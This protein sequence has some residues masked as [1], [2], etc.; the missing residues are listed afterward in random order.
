MSTVVPIRAPRVAIVGA[1]RCGKSTLARRMAFR[2]G[3]E[4]WHTDDL[5]GVL[6]WSEASDEVARWMAHPAP[7]LVEGVAVARALRKCLRAA[8]D[9]KP[10]DHV[11]Y[12]TEAVAPQT[13]GQ[14]AMGKGIAT[15]WKA[16]EP[17]LLA[18]GVEVTKGRAPALPSNGARP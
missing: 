9:E 14:I 1:P 13:Q 11:I 15:V 16:I 5:C 10:V 7:W 2:L 3:L 17:A 12:L 18:L 8:P 4:A 6:E